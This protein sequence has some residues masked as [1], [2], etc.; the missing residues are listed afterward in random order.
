MGISIIINEPEVRYTNTAAYAAS[1]TYATYANTSEY[2]TYTLHALTADVAL[3]SDEA[4][5][6]GEIPDHPCCVKPDVDQEI[7]T[8]ATPV[9]SPPSGQYDIEQYIQISTTTEGAYITYG[10]GSSLT[11]TYAGGFNLNSNAS[12][13]AQ[14]HKT[15]WISSGIA[16]ASYTFSHIDPR[17]PDP[18]YLD[19]YMQ[20]VDTC[21]PTISSGPDTRVWT[22]GALI[23]NYLT[24]PPESS[25]TVSYS[26][27]IPIYVGASSGWYVPNNPGDYSGISS[28]APRLQ[29]RATFATA[30]PNISSTINAYYKHEL[31]GGFWVTGA[32]RIPLFPTGRY[33][34]YTKGKFTQKSQLYS[35]TSP[36]ILGARYGPVSCTSVS[37]MIGGSGAQTL[38]TNGTQKC[39]L[40]GIA[41]GSD[42][43]P[44]YYGGG[45]DPQL[46]NMG[47]AVPFGGY[48]PKDID[49]TE[50]EK[51]KAFHKAIEDDI[52][53]MNLHRD[54]REIKYNKKYIKADEYDY[55]ELSIA[56]NDK[57][58]MWII[59]NN[60]Y[61]I[62][63]DNN[64]S[65]ITLRSKIKKTI[66]INIISDNIIYN[67]LEI[68]FL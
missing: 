20:I 9:F 64:I 24:I 60:I 2:A 26:Y 5:L 59:D 48:L 54:I 27:E 51:L 10:P 12:Y 52:A 47:P 63:N 3:E 17:H 4:D 22:Y 39:L 19:A 29:M 28:G 35:E 25:S 30:D 18:T 7:H 50:E 15:G 31:S 66:V 46:I 58:T 38:I 67:N 6:A 16:T 43:Q 53:E 61:I 23:T 37:C 1:A 36:A 11:T 57:E 45:P 33:Y 14:A 55:C 42:I 8:V 49:E 34:I 13:S 41:L 62:K 32:C 65:K 56:T 44:P 21:L 68:Y 40:T